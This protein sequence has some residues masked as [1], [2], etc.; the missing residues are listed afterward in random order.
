MRQ[1][2]DLS[3]RGFLISGTAAATLGAL[4]A[5]VLAQEKVF[6]LGALNSITGIGGPYG[7]Y[8]LEAIK[9]AVN[10]VNEAGG[11]AGRKFQLFAEDDQTKPEA[12]VLAVKKLVE[13]NKVEA[14]VGIWPSSVGLATMPITND[15]NVITMNTCG[16]PEMLTENKKGLAWMFQASNAIF[17]NA[18]AEVARQ[19]GFKRP[20][21]MAFNNSTFV[22]QANYFKNAWESG[23]GKVEAFVIY[24]PN[25]SSYRTELARVLATKPDV[26]SLSAYRPDATI[27][28]KEWFQT[29]QDCKFIMP[30]WTA[31]EDLVKALGK[32]ATEGLISISNV[33]ADKHE[34]YKRFAAAFRKVAKREPDIFAA[35]SYDM[36]ITLALALEAAGPQ[37][38]VAG[39]N[40]KIRSV[41]GVGGTRVNG[42]AEGRDLL[43]KG[44]KVD[45][46]GASSRLDFGK[47]GETVPDF[48]VSDIRDGKLVL[49]ETIPG[50]LPA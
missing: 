20:A 35:Q 3:R 17:G 15:A 34:A 1:P 48:G 28:L 10:E 25:Q 23:G 46:E 41:T 24:E 38:D 14:V 37:A 32:E 9:I 30:G 22:G 11:A 8:M 26:I 50:K 39:V 45:Y 40:G 2:Y 27:I 29:G 5:P 6:R 18:F 16:A 49:K 12:A 43:R 19:R 33:A 21:V 47:H 36:V 7:P 13:I 4:Q 44:E 42:F 31:N